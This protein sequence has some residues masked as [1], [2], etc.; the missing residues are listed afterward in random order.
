[1][2][3]LLP[4]IRLALT[5]VIL[6][7]GMGELMLTLTNRMARIVERTRFVAEAV[8]A[9]APAERAQL[10]SQLEIMWRRALL[11]L[12]GA[13]ICLLIGSLLYFLRNILASLHALHPQ[14]ELARKH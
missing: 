7:S 9:A 12:F 5:P 13:G 8:P 3:S 1:L 10:V 11:D 4:I 2:S 14:V 6:I